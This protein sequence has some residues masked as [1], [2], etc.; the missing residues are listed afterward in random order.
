MASRY[1]HFKRKACWCL[2]YILQDVYRYLKGVGRQLMIWKC[3]NAIQSYWHQRPLPF[4]G[5]FIV[6]TNYQFWLKFGFGPNPVPNP[7]LS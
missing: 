7:D 4:I 1:E 2:L 3:R 5:E 6:G